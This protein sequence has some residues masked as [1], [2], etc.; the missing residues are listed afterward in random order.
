MFLEARCD[1]A[2]VFDPVKEAFDVV[3]FL[4][5]GPGSR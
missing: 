2:E 4:V 3:A 1:T 5:K